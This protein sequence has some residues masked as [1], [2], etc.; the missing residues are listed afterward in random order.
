MSSTAFPFDVR[1]QR[2]IMRL[3]M[4]DDVFA[5]RAFR[6]V[7]P[8]FFTERALGWMFV[9][10]RK[11]YEEYSRRCT[12]LPLRDALRAAP[13]EH[14]TAYT[15]EIDACVALGYVAEADYVKHELREFVRRALFSRSHAESAKL[16]NDGKATEAYDTTMTA[17][18]RI[19]EV[20]FENVDRQWF[21]EELPDRQKQRFRDATS[22]SAFSTG[23]P[24][25]DRVT[26]GGAHRGEV[27]MVIA[28][29]KV[30]KTTWLINQGAHGATIHGARVAHFS[31]EG[32]GKQIAD[33][34]EASFS[35][36]LYTDIKRGDIPANVY[37][38]MLDEYARLRRRLV[39]RTINEWETTVLDLE[40][41]LKLLRADGFVPDIL[42]CDYL[43]LLRARNA[44]KGMSKTDE[45]TEVGQDLKKLTNRLDVLTHTAAQAQRPKDGME[46]VEH[47]LYGSNIADCYGLVRIMDFIGS[48]NATNAERE[49]NEMRFFAELY[50]DGPMG[51]CWRMKNDFARMRLGLSFEP[52]DI[53][54]EKKKRKKKKDEDE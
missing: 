7:E 18:D 51:K 1:F 48:L 19:R 43:G 21:F 6:Y 30:G 37:R 31:L 10:S 11:Y 28:P 2:A 27:W 8:G 35:N 33:R 52:L 45:Q 49:R 24:D 26:D 15:D 20:D 25:I 40:A 42:I 13:P 16:Y 54:E 39:I 32:K 36:T 5:A 46:D 3:V 23:I 9:T 17:L 12:E 22:K 44:T 50:R 41:E 38:D 47:I 34:Y 53:E 29:A 4:I 14:V